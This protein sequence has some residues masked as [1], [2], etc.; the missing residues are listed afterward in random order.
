MEG[1]TFTIGGKNY[2]TDAN[3]EITVKVPVSTDKM[4]ESFEYQI[5]EKET[6]EGYDT[7]DGSATVTVSCKSEFA[8]ADE[9][10]LTNT[11][12]K[13]CEFSKKGSEDFAWNGSK[14]MLTVTNNRSLADSI[15]IRK[16]IEGLKASVL[17]ENGLT[18]TLS[19]PDDFEP[20]EIEFSDFEEVSDGVYE[21]T[22]DG[23]IPTGEYKV[24]ESGAEVDYFTVTVNGDDEAQEVAKDAEAVFEI[25]NEYEAEKAWYEVAKI[26]DD[27]H[28]KDG[29]RPEQ[30]EIHLLANGE[31]VDK[32]YMSMKDAVIIGVEDEEYTTGDVW[33][34]VWEELP[35]VD[36]YAELISY[37]AE[38]VL[39]SD[40]YEQ[41]DMEGY[42]YYT[43]FV[44]SHQLEDPCVEGGCGGD[45]VPPVAPET[46]RLTVNEE[47]QSSQG[48]VVD[49]TFV[50]VV[51]MG[52]SAVVLY[53]AA[54]FAKRK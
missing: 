23:R 25:V 38:E 54:K 3:G 5:S 49:N 1:V 18:F 24:V 2:T 27:A 21:Y 51:L 50:L 41:T 15:T 14:L 30:L 45:I 20:M 7:V 35:L 46:G 33:V 31:V 32:V 42:E 6:W 19:G 40:D 47:L 26:W 4:E 48:A 37:T 44:N 53:C 8:K 11:Y 36:E 16:K 12:T 22:F 9:G 28:D 34:Y 10:T 43:L 17:S 52:V 13:N 29:K 39:E